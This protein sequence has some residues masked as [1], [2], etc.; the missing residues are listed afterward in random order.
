MMLSL[1]WLD[2]CLSSVKVVV[3]AVYHAYF[4]SV[5]ISKQ[6][7][8]YLRKADLIL[9][10]WIQLFF[11]S[12]D[13][14]Q[15]QCLY[16]L[17]SYWK[18][19]YRPPDYFQLMLMRKS[20]TLCFR[21]WVA[22]EL[23]YSGWATVG[24]QDLSWPATWL[25]SSSWILISRFLR[26]NRRSLWRSIWQG[27]RWLGQWTPRNLWKRTEALNSLKYRCTCCMSNTNYWRSWC[28]RESA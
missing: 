17:A 27:W 16:V 25:D 23:R 1:S 9:S 14:G 7:Y 10:R 21:N 2:R 22:I 15:L 4:L 3:N 13:L 20:Q 19:H 26:L 8:L 24:H 6:I 5:R 28:G 12:I 11:G 18:N